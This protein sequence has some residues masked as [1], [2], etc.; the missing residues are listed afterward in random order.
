MLALCSALHNSWFP[1]DQIV[2]IASTNRKYGSLPGG[3]E[4]RRDVKFQIIQI[5]NVGYPLIPENRYL[6]SFIIDMVK[7]LEITC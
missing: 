6:K 3:L 1:F 2:L 4:G 5:K 7:N